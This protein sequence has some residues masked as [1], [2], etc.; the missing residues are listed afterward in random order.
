MFNC[1]LLLTPSS[2]SGTTTCSTAS[3]AS[4]SEWRVFLGIDDEPIEEQIRNLGGCERRIGVVCLERMR[5]ALEEM[6]IYFNACGAQLLEKVQS[7]FRTNGHVTQS[8]KKD[9]RSKGRRNRA[10]C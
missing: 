6:Q 5:R 7:T 2:A 3:A 4:C 9:C 10:C 1:H 8:M